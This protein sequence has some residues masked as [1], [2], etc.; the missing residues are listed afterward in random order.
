MA[1]PPQ[2]EVIEAL[3]RAL[4]AHGV[5]PQCAAELAA[6]HRQ[7][8][9]AEPRVKLHVVPVAT[10]WSVISTIALGDTEVFKTQAAALARARERAEA[11]SGSIVLHDG[12]GHST[13]MAPR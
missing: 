4:E 9:A 8:V 5:A 2:D 6:A 13:T 3:R 1:E 10:G 12:S 11:E 7:D